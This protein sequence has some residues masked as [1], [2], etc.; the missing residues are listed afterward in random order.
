MTSSS[1]VILI[2]SYARLFVDPLVDESIK[3]AITSKLLRDTDSI[4]SILCHILQGLF[5]TL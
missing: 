3:T 5:F 1:D 2:N 4:L